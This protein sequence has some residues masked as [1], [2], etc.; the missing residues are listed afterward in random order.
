MKI[1]EKGLAL[2]KEFEGCQLTAYQ[3]EVGVWTIGSGVTN[4][5]KSITKTTI[6]KGLT[7]TKEKAEEWLRECLNKRYAPLISKYD[8]R[9]GWNQNEFDALVSFAYNIGSIDGLT[10]NGS[11]SKSVISN[12]LLEYNKAGG[13]V[14]AGLTRR[15]KAER[16]LFLTPVPKPE[17]VEDERRREPGVAYF[18]E[19]KN[20]AVTNITEFLHNRGIGAGKPN[21]SKIASLNADSPEVKKALFALAQKG[22]LKKPDGLKKWEKK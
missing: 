22:L 14:Y 15:R 21:L 20:K 17:P 13:K 16:E 2:I 9:Y 11:R 7:I 1:S 8:T 4:S 6:K 19:L 5:D 12:K 3:D 10:A 18:A